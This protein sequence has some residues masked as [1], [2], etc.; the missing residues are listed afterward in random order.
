MIR[1]ARPRLATWLARNC[2][3]F[4]PLSRG[5]PFFAHCEAA[6]SGVFLL[7]SIEQTAKKFLFMHLRP[8]HL[9]H[10]PPCLHSLVGPTSVSFSITFTSPPPSSFFLSVPSS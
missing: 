3:G 10:V 6:K 8:F 9:R 2:E 5:P 7:Q 1:E 4:T